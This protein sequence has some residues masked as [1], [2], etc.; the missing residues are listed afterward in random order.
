[1]GVDLVLIE[2]NDRE[3]NFTDKLVQRAIVEFSSPK[4]LTE[5][6]A[7]QG[8]WFIAGCRNR[9]AEQVLQK[10][11]DDGSSRWRHTVF[12]DTLPML[13]FTATGY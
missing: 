5:S 13:P 6:T 8:R 4:N 10:P 7:S 3:L 12:A 1:L 2:R 9:R 11:Q